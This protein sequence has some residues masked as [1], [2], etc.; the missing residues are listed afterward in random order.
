LGMI[1]AE[2][3]R[4]LVENTAWFRLTTAISVLGIGVLVLNG[5][6]AR[7]VVSLARLVTGARVHGT[8]FEQA[9]TVLAALAIALPLPMEITWLRHRMQPESP[10]SATSFSTVLRALLFTSRRRDA[11]PAM[12]HH[13]VAVRPVVDRRLE[14][15][16]GT[17]VGLYFSTAAWL[18]RLVPPS[19]AALVWALACGAGLG[20]TIYS[21]GRARLHLTDDWLVE[22]EGAAVPRHTS[23]WPENYEEG[24]Q[25][26]IKRFWIWFVI[27]ATIWIG[28]FAC[29]LFR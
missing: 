25:V 23:F 5:Q 12:Q 29:A 19:L 1:G 2:T 21:L 9:A 7:F 20:A 13:S 27:A 15:I 11:T 10:G 16:R 14:L 26:W 22:Q 3:R 6:A 17:T 4:L 8:L 28:P 24:G 18:T